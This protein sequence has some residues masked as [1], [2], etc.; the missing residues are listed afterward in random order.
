[1]T[2]VTVSILCDEPPVADAGADRSVSR[3]VYGW[4][5]VLF[6]ANNATAAHL[7]YSWA[8]IEAPLARNTT[9]I[10]GYFNPHG[11]TSLDNVAYNTGLYYFGVVPLYAGT[12]VIELA[13]YDGCSIAKDTV[14]LNVTCDNCDLFVSASAE[15]FYFETDDV[16][17][18]P[19]NS[20]DSDVG[21]YQF[22]EYSDLGNEWILE[23]TSNNYKIVLSTTDSY[24]TYNLYQV[25]TDVVINSTT[26]ETNI[27]YPPTDVFSINNLVGDGIDIFRYEGTYIIITTTTVTDYITTVTEYLSSIDQDILTCQVL[28]ESASSSSTP[29]FLY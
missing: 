28:L 4:P 9:G 15:V 10:D 23:S 17:S 16:F 25:T 19:V 26:T 14:V 13:V 8:V 1:M 20:L 27:T 5:E 22:S 24:K 7:I 21:N 12:Y 6:F 11:Y 29:L 2:N 3:S 18:Y